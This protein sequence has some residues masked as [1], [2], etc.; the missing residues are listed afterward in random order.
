MDDRLKKHFHLLK[1][2]HTSSPKL[3]KAILKNVDKE[4]VRCIAECCHN[5]L[6]GNIKVT[7]NQKRHLL[8]HKQALRELASR[9]VN[10]HKKKEILNQKGGFLPALL[11]PLLAIAG[12]VLAEWVMRK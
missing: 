3:R 10:I 12:S 9:K 5:L 1:V 6:N 4:A 11:T 7:D 8:R 2:L